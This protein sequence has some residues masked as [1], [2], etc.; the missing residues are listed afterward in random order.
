MS[1]YRLT[2][3]S[4]EQLL[5]G[6][7]ALR[8]QERCTMAALLAHIAEI[9]GRHLYL[10]AGF[11]SMR[12]YCVHEL[13]LS[14]DAAAKRIQVARLAHGI[15]AIFPAIADG[16]LHLGAVR[17]LASHLTR[18]NAEELVAVAAHRTVEEIEVELARLYPQPEALR[19]DDGISPQV[20]VPQQPNLVEHAT[21]HA[22]LPAEGAIP[23]EVAP[24]VRT[25]IAPLSP[26]RYTLQ[27]TLPGA[28]HDKLR[29]AQRLLGHALPAGDVADVLDRALTLLIGHL[30]RR[31]F[32]APTHPR[33]MRPTTSPRGIPARVRR[34]V[35]EREEGRCASIDE[36]GR[37]CESAF[38]LEFD[39]I[40]PV[41]RG[42]KSVVEN[43]RL[44]CRAHN[45]A[46]AEAVF[47]Q[48]FVESKRTSRRDGTA[49][50]HVQ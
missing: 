47:G 22:S 15:P 19:L 33:N 3:L 48:E 30:E 12:A 29:R 39:H 2:H 36:L 6:F 9:D 34:A 8:A 1:T 16:R 32:G 35:Y 41:A 10:R 27:V 28:T 40:V 11:E 14:E 42:G 26:D 18:T 44:V 23:V 20:V 43:L 45:Q 5:A 13:R 49:R 38:R 24:R 7:V 25:K 37:R 46:A 50:E 17:A 21:W 4:N 31:K